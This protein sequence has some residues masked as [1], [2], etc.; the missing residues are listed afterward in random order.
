M[1]KMPSKATIEANFRRAIPGV[2][3]SY[4]AGIESTTNWKQSAVDGQDLYVTAMQNQNVLA[5]RLKGLG[6]VS[7]AE[8]RNAALLKGV[9]RIGPG[10]EAGASK[11]AAG[12]EPIRVALEQVTLTA[13]TSDPM[14][15]IDN[16]VKP[17]VQ[18]AMN[19]SGKY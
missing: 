17:I 12:Y 8:W 13:R 3:N 18:A 7:D 10:M 5:R 1:V 15:N 4:K 14:Q 16:R 19:A 11:Q 2:A 6:K 9:S